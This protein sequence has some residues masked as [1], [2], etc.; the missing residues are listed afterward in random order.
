V[1]G[2]SEGGANCKTCRPW[3]R[4]G[5]RLIAK[6]PH[7]CLCLWIRILWPQLEFLKFAKKI[8]FYR[9]RCLDIYHQKSHI[10]AIY[11]L[12]RFAVASSV[13]P[14][15][16]PCFLPHLLPLRR[17]G[18]RP[19]LSLPLRRQR[20]EAGHGKGPTASHRARRERIRA[21]AGLPRGGL[22]W[23]AGGEG[24]GAAAREAGGGG[25]E[26]RWQRGR[27]RGARRRAKVRDRRA[28]A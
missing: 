28:H 9:I 19:S 5:G 4:R 22:D 3:W 1:R 17:A 26:P 21:G 11:Y 13:N 6:C 7:L 14:G 27:R 2:V 8:D 18:A 23:P 15:G 24:A 16:A 25:A 12:H 10:I 20:G